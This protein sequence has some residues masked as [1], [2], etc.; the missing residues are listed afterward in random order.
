MGCG[1]MKKCTL[2]K[3]NMCESIELVYVAIDGALQYAPEKYQDIILI[4]VS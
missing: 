1:I 4:R 2:Y 3:F